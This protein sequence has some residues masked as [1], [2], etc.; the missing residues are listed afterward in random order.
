MGCCGGKRSQI[1]TPPA[2][3]FMSPHPRPTPPMTMQ[4]LT[5]E[6]VTFEYVGKTAIT[7]L[8]P[9]SRM[10][11]RFHRPGERVQVDHRDVPYLSGVPNLRRVRKT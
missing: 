10:Q 4:P 3:P 1:S 11:Y 6:T 2:R 9:M 7:V 8:G 5:T